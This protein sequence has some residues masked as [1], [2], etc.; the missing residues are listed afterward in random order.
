MEFVLWGAGDR[1]VRLLPHIGNEN[2]L[3]IIDKD[4]NKQGKQLQGIDI[5]SYDDFKVKYY[6]KCIILTTAE[7]VVADFLKKEG[8]T[9]FLYMNDCPEDFQS[10]NPRNILKKN[11]M[12]LLNAQNDCIV[13]GNNLYAIILYQWGKRKQGDNKV[14]VVTGNDISDE[15]FETF[16]KCCDGN[17]CKNFSVEDA[18]KVVLNTNKKQ[19]VVSDVIIKKKIQLAR[20]SEK[21]VE[22]RNDRI[23]KFKNIHSGEKCFIIGLGPSVRFED[24]DYLHEKKQKCF[25]MNLVHKAYDKTKWRPDYYVAQDVLIVNRE[26]QV[27]DYL[28][29]IEAFISDGSKTFCQENHKDNIY[30]NHMACYGYEDEEMPFSEDFAQ[31]CYMSGTVSYACI[32]LAVYMGFSEIYL[33]G[34]DFSGIGSIIEHFYDYETDG[35]ELSYGHQFYVC[36]ISAKKYAEEHGI[37][38]F[39]ASRG[40][41]LEMFERVNLE[42]IKL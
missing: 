21:I 41:D 25:S 16:N 23:E 34:I 35:E 1:A 29:G 39:N 4:V 12:E 40:G 15:L 42:D 36:Y 26:K 9:N 30:I 38:I 14:K 32:Q 5:I 3:A 18:E 13:Y 20:Y 19:E 28:D 7:N 10:P 31:I 33:Y 24:L 27:L 11:V 8:Y 17:V 2:V 22:Y 6:G 37:Q